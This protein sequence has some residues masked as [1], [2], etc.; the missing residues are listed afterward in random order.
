MKTEYEINERMQELTK[1]LL[2]IENSIQAELKK[3]HQKRDPR[4][5][6]FLDKEKSVWEFGLAQMAWMLSR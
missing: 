5:L 6:W 1:K 4:L 2:L 3:P